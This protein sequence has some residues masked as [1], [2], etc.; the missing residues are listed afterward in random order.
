MEKRFNKKRNTITI[1][2]IV[3][4]ILLLFILITNR[5][6]LFSHGVK[7]SDYY[8]LSEERQANY[9]KMKISYGVIEERK[10]GTEKFDTL[11]GASV[12]DGSVTSDLNGHD[13]S[14]FD[15]YVRTFD[16]ITYVLELGIERNPETTNPWD[17]LTGGVIKVKITIPQEDDLLYLSVGYDA[18]MKDIRYNTTKTELTCY[19]EIPK[20]KHAA[21]GIQELT[22]TFYVGGYKKELSSDYTPKFEV[23]MEGNKNDNEESTAE[24]VLIEDTNLIITGKPQARLYFSSGRINSPGT[25][26]GV[27]G[28]YYNFAT[29]I[30]NSGNAT[31]GYIVPQGPITST[32]RIEYYYK[33]ADLG[34]SWKLLTEDDDGGVEVLNGIR[35]VSYGRPC[36]ET[37]GFWPDENSNYGYACAFSNGNS[38]ASNGSFYNY[39]SGEVTASIEGNK[40]TFTNVNNTFS[41]NYNYA[42]ILSNGFEIFIPHYEPD[43]G[44]YEYQIKLIDNELSFYNNLGEYIETDPQAALNTTM[45]NTFTGN[46]YVDFNSS[47]SKNDVTVLGPG[48]TKN[49]YIYIC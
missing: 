42:T 19:Y 44:N 40:I 20:E 29:V 34:G 17:E 4:V 14:F 28:T 30:A 25:L 46:I 35:L 39:D 45:R 13:V 21:G 37:P 10:T 36:E 8:A 41:G 47:P 3:I 18:W 11:D 15:E 49:A 31:K 9:D 32:F 12:D 23:W 24:S 7:K 48:N 26:D 2:S 33:N 16:T 38:S 43:D 22:F 27:E 5:I 1:V 6:N